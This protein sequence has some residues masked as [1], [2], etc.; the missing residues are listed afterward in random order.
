MRFCNNIQ[1][2]GYPYQ[3]KM[4]TTNPK[5]YTFYGDGS[6]IIRWLCTSLLFSAIGSDGRSSR[7]VSP[8]YPAWPKILTL[9]IEDKQTFLHTN[10][11]THRHFYTQ[12]LLHTGV[13]KQRS[14]YTHTGAF[15]HRRF[16]TQTSLD[17]GSVTHRH[18]PTQTFCHTE[19]LIYRHSYTQTRLPTDA[20]TQRPFTHRGFYTQ[21]LCA[22]T[23]LHRRLWHTKAWHTDT[24]THRCFY[25]QKVAFT[26]RHNYTQTLSHTDA[27][28]HSR[29]D[30]RAP[31][32]TDS[33][34]ALKHTETFTHRRFCIQMPLH[35]GSFT[36]RPFYT[37]TLLLYTK[38]LLPFLHRRFHT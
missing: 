20:F 3:N 14:F 15:T 10:S 23:L 36:H 11:F 33:W 24:C 32:L 22:E 27:F 35:A 28:T 9:D 8:K 26:H 29:S 38:T 7:A 13:L 31:L 6:T 37:Q 17:T 19:A 21:T 12:M 1:Q 16:Y 34:L 30:T 2:K 18:F 4:E 5:V 25:T